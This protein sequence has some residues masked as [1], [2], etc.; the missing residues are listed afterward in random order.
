M[1]IYGVSSQPNGIIRAYRDGTTI[2]MGQISFNGDNLLFE[3]APHDG[4][5]ILNSVSWSGD[6]QLNNMT[7]TPDLQK[8]FTSAITRTNLGD[9]VYLRNRAGVMK[10]YE[11]SGRGYQVRNIDTEA[12]EQTISVFTTG[13]NV[14]LP[15]QF[16]KN[17]TLAFFRTDGSVRLYDVD[18]QTVVLDSFIDIPSIVTVDQEH[19]NIVTVRATDNLVQV[20]DLAI[21]PSQMVNFTA[22]PGAYERYHGEEVSI[23]V[24]GSNNEPV[25]GA[26]VEWSVIDA[27]LVTPAKGKITPSIS[28]TNENGVATAMYCPPGLDWISGD[29]EVITAVTRI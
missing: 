1:F 2:V 5:V 22:T 6:F 23:T 4:E 11:Q 24:Q 20:Y 3:S 21:E 16:V 19:Q 27:D 25:E 7:W 15:L 10:Y 28:I 17:Q 18:T 13:S 14:T 12:I 29:Q 8:P 9:G 26:R